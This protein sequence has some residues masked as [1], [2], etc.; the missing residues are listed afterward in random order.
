MKDLNSRKFQYHKNFRIFSHQRISCLGEKPQSLVLDV[1]STYHIGNTT[2][3]AVAEISVRSEVQSVKYDS[4]KLSG[5]VCNTPKGKMEIDS[6]LVI[7]ASG[8]SSIVARRS[9]L[10]KNW[11]RYGIGVE[12]ECYCDDIDPET[13]TLMVG[14]KYSDAGCLDFPFPTHAENRNGVGLPESSCI[15]L[16]N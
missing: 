2:A 1:R 12:Y 15:Q 4:N 11:T 10:V 5:I 8:F 9:G 7:D 3:K 13:W 14:Q 16:K 6:R